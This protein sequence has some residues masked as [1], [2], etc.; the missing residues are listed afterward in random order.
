MRKQVYLFPDYT[1]IAVGGHDCSIHMYH[2]ES[3]SDGSF[4]WEMKGKCVV[5]TINVNVIGTKWQPSKFLL[6]M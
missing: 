3:K 4:A 6:Q 2:F 1:I 5:S